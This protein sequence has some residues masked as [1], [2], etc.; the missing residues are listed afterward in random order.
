MFIFLS[1]RAY[2]HLFPVNCEYGNKH[3]EHAVA[4][5]KDGEI[6]GHLPNLVQASS[7]LSLDTP[8]VNSS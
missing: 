2:W 4:V 5:L 6:V 8:L 3:D 1:R 7:F